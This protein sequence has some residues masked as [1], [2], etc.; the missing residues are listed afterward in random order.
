MSKLF[1][2]ADHGRSSGQSVVELA[3]CMPVLLLLLLGT[4]DMGRVFFDYI[5]MRNAVVEGATY[6]SRHP[7]DTGGITTAVVRH[8]IPADTAITTGTSG[9]CFQPQGG[10]SVTVT[11][12]RTFTPIFLGGLNIVAPDVNWN[13]TVR[14]SSTIRCMT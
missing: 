1:Q 2:R 13:F 4:V 9:E 12:T 6:G 11:A 7:G 14:A 5:E 10:G 3:I 8:G